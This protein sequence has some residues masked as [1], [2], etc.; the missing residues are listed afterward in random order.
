MK[1]NNYTKQL[2]LWA[3]LEMSI[4]PNI[5]KPKKSVSIWIVKKWKNSFR[6]KYS[7]NFPLDHPSLSLRY[8]PRR[9]TD[10]FWKWIDKKEL[11]FIVV[12]GKI[13]QFQGQKGH[14][15]VKAEPVL[16]IDIESVPK[17]FGCDLIERNW[18]IVVTS[19]FDFDQVSKGRK[20]IERSKSNLS[21]KLT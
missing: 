9:C 7:D 4:L 14:R 2:S 5:M 1:K 21:E 17:M 3:W 6:K 20:G 19:Q 10:H 11:R 18:V 12:K 13:Y 16:D 15:K 8:W